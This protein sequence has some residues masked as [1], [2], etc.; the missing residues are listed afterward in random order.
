L[1]IALCLIGR[2]PQTRAADDVIGVPSFHTVTE[3]DTLLDIAREYDLGYVEVRAANPG[4]D[5]W[6]PSAGNTLTLPRQHVLPD[7]PRRGIVINL[8]ELRLYYFPARGAPSSFPIGIGGEGR[9][10]PVGHTTIARKRIHPTWT[11]TKSEREE[12]PDLSASVP[13]G[14][15]NPMGDRALYLGWT[16]YAIHGTDKPY[17]IA[18]ATATAASAC[19]RTTSRPC[20]ILSVSVRR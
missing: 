6:L 12:D 17:S 13:P 2:A 20:S 7:A 1:A 5:P 14:P 3:S 16:G 19:I 11:P 8:P 18:G 10:T 15:D 4:V 9:E